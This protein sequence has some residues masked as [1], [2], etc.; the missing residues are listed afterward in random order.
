M[1]LQPPVIRRQPMRRVVGVVL[2]GVASA[3]AFA[4]GG[5]RIASHGVQVVIEE[6]PGCAGP[7]GGSEL[8]AG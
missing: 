2:S 3:V 1:D 4:A 8:R 6:G 5:Q 7:W